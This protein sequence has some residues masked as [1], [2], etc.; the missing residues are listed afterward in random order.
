MTTQPNSK[1]PR[2]RL[3]KLA[4]AAL[5]GVAALGTAVAGDTFKWTV[6]YLID[7]SQPV[8]GESQKVWPRRNRGLA[9]SPDG[10]FLYTGYH[11]AGNGVGEVRKIAVAYTENFSKATV[12][13][14]RGPLGKSLAC[15]DKGRVYIANN[16]DILVYD[17]DLSRLIATIAISSTEG[18]NCE[19]VT[20]AREGNELALYT[21]N[22]AGDTIV[23]LVLEEKGGEITGSK[24]AGFDGSGV[25]TIPNA[26]DLRGIDLDANGRV[27]VTDFAGGRVFRVSKDGKEIKE[28]KIAGALDVAVD[29]KRAYVSRG[30]ERLVAVFDT[31]TFTLLGN[32]AVPWDE[33]E[34]T[35]TGN[36]R[37]GRIS[38]IVAIPGKGFYVANETGQTAHQK[39]TYGK[40]D[41]NSDKVGGKVY[42]DAFLDDNEPILRALEVKE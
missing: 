29:G 7:N 30:I 40:V 37:R 38:G 18:V 17:E 31:E 36:N 41:M 16:A 34:L 2:K 32:L 27:W 14:L 20:V 5:A 24:A 42:R 25:V 21:S 19:G 15:D 3:S 8:F 39:S 22:R 23:R 9:M 35:P 1:P 4:A 12:S 10:K 6:Q 28:A 13:I 33:L 26:G 11:H